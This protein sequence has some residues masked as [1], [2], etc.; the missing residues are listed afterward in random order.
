MRTHSSFAGT[1]LSLFLAGAL[2]LPA[3]ASAQDT[4]RIDGSTG[5]KPLVSAL[6]DAFMKQQAGISIEI[7][8]GLDGKARIEALEGG[9]IDIAT[10][11]HGLKIDELTQKGMAVH[12][13]AVTPVVFATNSGVGVSALSEDEICSIYSGKVTNWNQLKGPDMPVAVFTRPNSEVDAEVVLEGV[14]CLKGMAMPASVTVAAKAGDMAK[15][16]E[17]T[18][19]AIG[20]T[21]STMVEQSGG[22]I[23]LVALNGVNPDEANLQAGK[24]TLVR[25]AFLV[26]DGSPSEAVSAFLAFVTSS[27]GR[28]VISANGAFPTKQ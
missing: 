24:Y 20:M 26:V 22:K 28:A 6:A 21:T 19:G 27:E 13:I 10:A 1:R 15:A 16:L 8:E 5:I 4:V 9:V 11:S 3:I 23:E 18:L 12:Q 17:S 25:E 2:L 7:G 14:S